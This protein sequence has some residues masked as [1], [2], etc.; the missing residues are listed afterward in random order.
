MEA[1]KYIKET[2]GKYS[3]SE[4]GTIRRNER[5]CID[6]YK[7]MRI[8]KER[9]IKPARAGS[10][11]MGV[12][13]RIDNRDIKR[14]I[15][16]IVAAEFVENTAGLLQVNHVDGNKRNNH[17]SN[18]EWITARGN[19]NHYFGSRSPGVTY[20]KRKDKWSARI[21]INGVR[22]FLGYFN[23]EEDAAKRYREESPQI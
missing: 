4:S 18:L 11:Y 6:K 5:V 22:H 19:T 21:M 8:V 9:I 12:T 7:R 20:V 1:W 23:S 16:R 14:Y 10:G 13:L 15:H 17:F 3:V 2:A